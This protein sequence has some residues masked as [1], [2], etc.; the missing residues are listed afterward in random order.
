M[1]KTQSLI[2]FDAPS[3]E[4]QKRVSDAARVIADGDKRVKSA[5][6]SATESAKS[7][8]AM[9][10]LC[11]DAASYVLGILDKHTTLRGDALQTLVD[12]VKESFNNVIKLALGK[13]Y[14]ASMRTR[15]SM[16]HNIYLSPAT[17]AEFA[18]WRNGV[19]QYGVEI[20]GGTEDKPAKRT[21]FEGRKRYN[22][23]RKPSQREAWKRWLVAQSKRANSAR[24]FYD[25]IVALAT[26]LRDDDGSAKAP[27]A[28]KRQTVKPATTEAQ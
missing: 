25:A 13:G 18:A 9:A 22:A 2:A 26:S 11:T 23:S 17:S 8:S 1:S 12:D 5:K 10:Q 4:V 24:S 3:A 16:V 6:D 20:A 28:P 19:A 21:Y 27:K 7:V 14:T 15:L